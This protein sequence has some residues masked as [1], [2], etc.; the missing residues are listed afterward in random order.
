M[1]GLPVLVLVVLLSGCTTTY[2]GTRIMPDGTFQNESRAGIPFTLPRPEFKLERDG[3]DTPARYKV[4]VTY[5]PDPNQRYTIRLS[6]ALFST[7]QF[8]AD[9]GED[10]ELTTVSG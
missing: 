4:S 7:V 2:K 8:G 5:V 1:R 9:L 6:P 10:G 3:M